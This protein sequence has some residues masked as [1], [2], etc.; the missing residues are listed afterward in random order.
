MGPENGDC[1]D[2]TVLWKCPDVDESGMVSLGD[3]ALIALHWRH[4]APP[5]VPTDDL[6]QVLDLNNDGTISLGDLAQ[7]AFHWRETCAL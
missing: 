6:D 4:D 7:V 1:D 3:L 2:V 5:N